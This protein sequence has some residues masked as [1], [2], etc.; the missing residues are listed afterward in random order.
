MVEEKDRALKWRYVER[1]GFEVLSVA[2]VGTAAVLSLALCGWAETPHVEWQPAVLSAILITGLFATALAH[3]FNAYAIKYMPTSNAG[4]FTYIDPVATVIVA[5]PLL[6]ETITFPY[7]LGSI[8]VFL[9]IF[10]AEKRL[11]WH[12]L[13]LL[14]R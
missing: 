5:V 12:P 14:R 1:P 8:F 6:H 4:I 9:G 10:V 13:H 2:Q 11:H 7:L 3:W